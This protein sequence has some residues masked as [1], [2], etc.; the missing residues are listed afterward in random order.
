M[1]ELRP[2]VLRRKLLT[3]VWGGRN[4][5]DRLG[6]TLP[7]GEAIGE[8][9][10]LFDR[11]GESS[12]FRDG[13]DGDLGAL[14]RK[15]DRELLGA[16]VTPGYGGRFPLLLKFIDAADWLSVQ[17]HPGPEQGKRH[18]DGPK[19]EAWLVL[20]AGPRAKIARGFRPGTTRAEAE[21]AVL[22]GKAIESL[23]HYM[24]P[25]AGD[26]I[27]IPAGVVH[28]IGP[29]VVLFEIQQNSDITF[30]I[31]DWGRDRPMHRQEAIEA[32]RVGDEGAP[33]VQPERIDGHGEWLLRTP[34]FRARRLRLETPATI[35]TEGSFKVLT[36][37]SGMAAVGW[38]SG[39]QDP[40]LPVRAFESVLIPASIPAVFV[41]PIGPME[42]LW[43]DGE[44]EGRN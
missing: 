3:K 6:M 15:H 20:H 2:V 30:R 35:G 8:S 5:A 10:E 27:S 43:M 38:R 29:D 14:L 28:A 11:D 37:L 26:V 22:D 33:T 4:L 7:A 9:W 23:L 17:V 40:P 34:H 1:P 39:G 12:A 44:S 31:W 16:R 21:A 19:N 42:F 41:S 36:M 13:S 24:V 18:G 32:M 25:R